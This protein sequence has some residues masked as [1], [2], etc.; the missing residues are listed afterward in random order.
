[1]KKAVAIK[2]PKDADVPFIC[3]K[4][5]GNLADLIINEAKKNNIHIEENENLVDILSYQEVGDAVSEETWQALATI[6]AFLL[7][8]K[9]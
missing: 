7:G 6:F 1:M 5:T 4:G 8:D 9:K 2:Y 3:A